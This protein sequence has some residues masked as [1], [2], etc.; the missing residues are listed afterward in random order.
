MRFVCRTLCLAHAVVAND[1]THLCIENT[2]IWETLC[3]CFGDS[4]FCSVYTH[5]SLERDGP[6]KSNM[7]A[8]FTGN[9]KQCVCVCACL[10]MFVCIKKTTTNRS[11]RALPDNRP[12]LTSFLNELGQS[13]TG[14]FP[15]SY[16]TL[17][18]VT[19][20]SIETILTWRR[21]E[22]GMSSYSKSFSPCY[23]LATV[24]RMVT[25]KLECENAHSLYQ[26]SFIV[27]LQ[28]RVAQLNESCRPFMYTYIE[29]IYK[30]LN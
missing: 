21:S 23:E 26:G 13:R 10:H 11:K 2:Q 16:L 3:H 12:H 27:I 29:H 19:S 22:H 8:N 15:R 25:W 18:E 17:R 4:G 5:S 9:S 30:Y 6:L 7:W 24:G 28:H 1:H 14:D 20:P